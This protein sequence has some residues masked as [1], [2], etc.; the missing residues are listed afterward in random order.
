MPGA[1][2]VHLLFA[3]FERDRL[4]GCFVLFFSQ[5]ADQITRFDEVA[6]L[7][8]NDDLTVGE[9]QLIGKPADL[10]GASY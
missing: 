8:G 2:A 7:P 9:K 1:N 10:I 6:C 3:S 5:L 4:S